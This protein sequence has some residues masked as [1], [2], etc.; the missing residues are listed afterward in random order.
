MTGELR[1]EA[2][3]DRAT[4]G[5]IEGSLLAMLIQQLTHTLQAC[6]TTLK[7]NQ[8]GLRFLEPQ[9][10]LQLRKLMMLTTAHL[11]TAFRLG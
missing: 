6:T 2:T 9:S 5:E 4:S 1:V 3:W 8:S 10:V 11:P 7:P